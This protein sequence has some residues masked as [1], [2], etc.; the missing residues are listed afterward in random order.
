MNTCEVCGEKATMIGM[1]EADDFDWEDNRHYIRRYFC[2]QHYADWINNEI[3]IPAER[4]EI[5]E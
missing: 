4:L 1:I 5:L 3:E 2:G